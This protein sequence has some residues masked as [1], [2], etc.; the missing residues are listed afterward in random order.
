MP[1]HRPGRCANLRPALIH[2]FSIIFC[3][4]YL[5]TW[6]MT[7]VV[8]STFIILCQVYLLTWETTGQSWINSTSH[9]ITLVLDGKASER[10]L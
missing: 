3:E 4:V 10:V 2:R 5:L 6:L 7:V 8:F 1:A 9:L